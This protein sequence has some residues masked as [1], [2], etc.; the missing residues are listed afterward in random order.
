MVSGLS[1]SGRAGATFLAALQWLTLPEAIQQA[2]NLGERGAALPYIL[3][4]RD[5]LQRRLAE[6]MRLTL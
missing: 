6:A 1:P 5:F 2:N 3:E 4:H